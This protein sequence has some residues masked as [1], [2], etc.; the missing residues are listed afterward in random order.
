SSAELK[1]LEAQFSF[2]VG[3]RDQ[4]T[5]THRAIRRI[6]R[7]RSQLSSLKKKLKG[8]DGNEEILD[9]M[10]S[11]D[12]QMTQIEETLYQTKNKS[13]QD[14]LN[15]PIRL[16]DKLAGVA[17]TA[18]RGDFAPTKQAKAVEMELSHAIDGELKKLSVLWTDALPEINNKIAEKG[19]S[20]L[21]LGEEDT[22]D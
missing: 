15:F 16:N 12:D 1:D 18:S 10:K 14:P 6:R 4:L 11:L 5:M 2:L 8:K 21:T 13:R 3:I 7:V 9:L 20:A 19:V 22:P 17:S